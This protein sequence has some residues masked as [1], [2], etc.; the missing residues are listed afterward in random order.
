MDLSPPSFPTSK[1]SGAPGGGRAAGSLLDVHDL[2]RCGGADLCSE[3]LLSD[4]P[5]YHPCD[6]AAFDH[7]GPALLCSPCSGVPPIKAGINPASWMLEVTSGEAEKRGG[8]DFATAFQDSALARQAEAVLSQW[9]CGIWRDALGTR[10]GALVWRVQSVAPV[11]R[12]Q[13]LPA[14]LPVALSAQLCCA[15]PAP[16]WCS[17]PTEDGP[18]AVRDVRAA[19]CLRQTWELTVRNWRCALASLCL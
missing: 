14:A 10:Q 16:S 19:G 3:H 6:L 12:A 17:Q 2:G 4:C 15:T 13:P 9:R 5:C 1:A 11:R 7:R 18:L 8:A